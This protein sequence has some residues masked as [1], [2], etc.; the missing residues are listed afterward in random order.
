MP[1]RDADDEAQLIGEAVR[2][3]GAETR[4]VISADTYKPAVAE[5]ALQAGAQPSLPTRAAALQL[6]ES[7]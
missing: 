4:L 3:I 6:L 5:A 7:A 2:H 1:V